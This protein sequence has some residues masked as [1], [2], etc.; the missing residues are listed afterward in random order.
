ME[1]KLISK[2][3]PGGK[4]K[5][6][7]KKG[8]KKEQPQNNN[9]QVIQG[10]PSWYRP[11]QEPVI[12]NMGGLGAGLVQQ[13]KIRDEQTAREEEQA[14]YQAYLRQS[15]LT[16][17]QMSY[18][19]WVQS[20]KPTSVPRPKQAYLSQ[21]TDTRSY[22]QREKDNKR[23]Q[24]ENNVN[25]IRQTYINYDPTGTA[26]TTAAVQM[27]PYVYDAAKGYVQNWINNP[28]GALAS[29][30]E[31][32]ARI[33]DGT[34]Q[35]LLSTPAAPVIEAQGFRTAMN[36]GNGWDMAQHG[37]MLGLSA[38]PWLT[39]FPIPERVPSTVR[40]P[41]TQRIG[42]IVSLFPHLFPMKCWD[43]IP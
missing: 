13:Q 16:P 43:Q 29:E 12:D 7:D 26:H 18:D 23:Q 25:Q 10:V 20:G 31:G 19:K 37:L 11:V 42:S 34:S 4:T 28:L 36:A 39:G 40:V 30:G 1:T 24:F 3:Q 6:D 27:T 8:K 15:G 21:D 14:Q 22:A 35:M 5:K 38:S 41:V 2:Y 32:L 33:A 9:Q 17:Y